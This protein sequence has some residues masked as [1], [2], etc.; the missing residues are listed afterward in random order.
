MPLTFNLLLRQ[1]DI[2]V[3][4]VRLL[5]HQDGRSIRGHSPYELWRDDR[6]AFDLYQAC[7]NPNNRSALSY[8]YWASFIV[9]AENDTLFAGLYQAGNAG[10]LK[11]DVVMPTTGETQAAG[12]CDFYELKP[13]KALA[14][15]IGRLVID[16]G[17]GTR[18]WIQRA[19]NQDKPILELR[20][21]FHEP[22]FPGFLE[23]MTALSSVMKLPRSWVAAL[24]AGRGVYLL[25][26]PKTK[27]QYVGSA[28]GTGGFLQRWEEYAATGHGGN[29]AL[30]SREPSDYQISILEVAGSSATDTDILAM[31]SRWKRKLQ[32]RE[33]GL[34]HN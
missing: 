4:D 15:C 13:L 21:S 18:T 33:M 12:S 24:S 14:D 29:V 3:P 26:C 27:E 30:K 6:P 22:P 7:Q 10:P 19:D 20:R 5:R 25:T 31:E 17:P 11:Q 32:S 23:F 2:E 9:S 16:W 1:A 28:T 8:P 34:N